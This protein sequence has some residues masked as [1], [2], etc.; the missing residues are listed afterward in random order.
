MSA[1]DDLIK[2]AAKMARGEGLPPNDPD[3]YP[4][5]PLAVRR[6]L[7]AHADISVEQAKLWAIE[8]RRIAGGLRQDAQAAGAV[9]TDQTFTVED[10]TAGHPWAWIT[11]LRGEERLAYIAQAHGKVFPW[12]YGA[13]NVERERER[14]AELVAMLQDGLRYRALRDSGRYAP[15]MGRCA[16]ALSCGTTDGEIDRAGLDAAADELMRQQQEGAA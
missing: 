12:Q 9:M 2:L 4:S 1:Y 10:A 3:A 7:A 14:A 16:W 15:G 11:I 13:R 6:A 8:A 5:K